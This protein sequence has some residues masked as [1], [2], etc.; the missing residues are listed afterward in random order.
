MS[1]TARM[2]VLALVPVIFMISLMALDQYYMRTMLG[3]LT[4]VEDEI[5]VGQII[6]TIVA[7]QLNKIVWLERGFLAADINDTEVFDQSVSRY[8]SLAEENQKL[9]SDLDR[10]FVK[11]RSTR[12]DAREQ[13]DALVAEV[14]NLETRYQEFDGLC[15][16]LAELLEGGDIVAAEDRLRQVEAKG[17]ELSESLGRLRD[18]LSKRS[19][20]AS[21]DARERGEFALL[22]T[23]LVATILLG[24]LLL[25]VVAVV[26]SINR[27]LGADPARLEA[28]TQSLAEGDLS[29][30]DKTGVRGVYKSVQET[31]KVL[32][33][34]IEKIYQAAERVQL[35]F[36][37]VMQG[38]S[39]LSSHMQ[40][41]ASSLEQ[42][43]ATMDELINLVEETAENANQARRQAES[44][45]QKA[46][47]GGLVINS[48]IGAMEEI[49][50]SSGKIVEI[51]QVVDGLAFQTNLLA[52]NA[53]VEA[54]RAGEQGR[55][56]AV[57]A[58][59][60]R[61][62]AGRSKEAAEEIKR[63]IQE[64]V[65]RVDAGSR[66]V[67]ESSRFLD[68]IVT[69]VRQ[70]SENI[71][72]IAESSTSQSAGIRQA[73]EALSQIDQMTQNNASVI[74]QAAANSESMSQDASDLRSLVSYFKL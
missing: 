68:E 34:V 1:F 74:E 65:S 37:E 19:V 36:A 60:V 31:I 42:V 41:Q 54:A 53:A 62:L 4:K 17:Y 12:E 71:G 15:A 48:T 28:L 44:A 55:G 40:E 47:E 11:L 66:M 3:A 43:S 18:V 38:N 25:V 50:E 13:I 49:R 61:T 22:V 10:N 6:S 67:D 58:N 7:N 59:E 45:N 63:L 51:I 39:A 33:E 35:S 23:V 29:D 70:I 9:F 2:T 16:S 52:L 21:A 69:A 46:E 72:R 5:P 8:R 26:Q 57:V 20:M 64:S 30:R 24:V 56:F 32:R 14:N 27:Q 73:N